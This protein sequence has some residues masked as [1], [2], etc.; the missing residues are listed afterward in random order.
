M[1]YPGSTFTRPWR[2]FM[3][4]VFIVTFFIVSPVIVGYTMGYRFDPERGIIKEIGAISIDILPKNA[5]VYINEQKIDDTIPIRLGSVTPNRYTIRITAPGYYTWSKDIEVRNK[6]TVY[7][8]EIELIQKN[9]P[10]LVQ[11]GTIHHISLSPNGTYLLYHQDI[12]KKTELHL[13]HTKTSEDTHIETISFQTHLYTQ[14]ADDSRFFITHNNLPTPNAHLYDA[15]NPKNSETI[16]DKNNASLKTIQWSQDAPQTTLYFSTSNSEISTYNQQTKT[17]T[18]ALSRPGIENWYVDND[19]FYITQKNTS[20]K[21]LE[22]VRIPLNGS[23]EEITNLSPDQFAFTDDSIPLWNIPNTSNNILLLT[24]K[25]ENLS[26]LITPSSKFSLA[27]SQSIVSSFNN[28][29]LL[30]NP[31]ELWGY[32]IQEAGPSL[33]NRS[34]EQLQSVFPLD[35]YNTLLLVW[36]EKSSIFFPYYRVMHDFLPNQFEDVEVDTKTRTIY[37]TDKKEKGLWHITY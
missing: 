29:L 24:K 36:N 19:A 7:I 30:W 6:Q 34:G 3:F 8:K 5:T 4:I 1:E 12:D 9:K 11:N 37:F 2:I 22:L 32:S 31:W 21:H 27:T 28:W 18:I 17:Q 10:A 20:T 23:K 15:L 13:K 26:Y 33:L 16:Q 35:K 14:W 25:D